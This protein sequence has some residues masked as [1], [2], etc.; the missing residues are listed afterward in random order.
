VRTL[1]ALA[2]VLAACGPADRRDRSAVH[3]AASTASTRGPD[4]IVLRIPRGGG[5]ARAYV[6]PNLDSVV[7]R[8]SVKAP[9]VAR[10]VAFDDGAGSLAYMDVNGLAGR[11]DLRVGSVSTASKAK[12][13]SVTSADGWAIYGTDGAG[14]VTRLTPSGDWRF[15]PRHKARLA[16]P[17]R[18]G[19]LLVVV[20]HDKGLAVLR[21]Y[22]PE[23]KVTDSVVVPRSDRLL[24][25]QAGDR[26]YLSDADGLVS[27]RARDLQRTPPIRIGD[28]LRALAPTPSGDRIFAARDSSNRV[29]IVD[30]YRNELQGDIQLP[31]MVG[32]LRMD[33]LGRYLLVG[34]LRGDSAW[35]VAIA[36]SRVIGGVATTWRADLPFVAPDGSIA[37]VSGDD[38]IFVDGETLKPK[39]KVAGGATDFWHLVVWNGFRA[40]ATQISQ[41]VRA[42]SADSTT[43][44]QTAVTPVPVTPKP[45][46]DTAVS[47]P[48]L[49]RPPRD[50]VVRAPAPERTGFTVSFAALLNQER[51][52]ALA[53]SISVDGQ[54]PR[55]VP[56]QTAGTTVYRVV[57]GPYPTKDEAERVGRASHHSYWVYEG[58][59]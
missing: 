24:H 43:G 12:F 8:S 29:A 1:V 13:A 35:V 41:P 53:V 6:Y 11:L 44:A 15:A 30:R 48:A 7:W 39:R 16:L 25:A 47:P 42:D 40:S 58:A 37:L 52:R 2:L 32:D 17:Q 38:V 20:E 9:D 22:P 51:A 10:A 55:V 31:G 14:E 5:I 28:A 21:V 26:V 49:P 50:T 56:S 57:L 4:Q 3:D 19:S 46:V 27:I 34:S 54:S 23:T 33:P 45:R 59:P 36:T 18:D